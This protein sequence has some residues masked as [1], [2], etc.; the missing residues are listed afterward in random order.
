MAYS[1]S[2]M[3][4]K[5]SFLLNMLERWD[6]FST[7]FWRQLWELLELD[8]VVQYLESYVVFFMLTLK[9]P[10]LYYVYLNPPPLGGYPFPRKE[11]VKVKRWPCY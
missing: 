8:T 6:I 2:K 10:K 3:Y 4:L 1:F 7:E 11:I 5:G 9:I